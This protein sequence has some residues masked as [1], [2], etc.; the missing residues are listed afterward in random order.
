MVAL[1]PFGA[2]IIADSEHP[3]EAEM[4]MRSEQSLNLLVVA[5][6]ATGDVHPLLAFARALK[7]RGHSVQTVVSSNGAEVAHQLGLN[8][9]V[10]PDSINVPGILPPRM[11]GFVSNSWVFQGFYRYA[12]RR[13]RTLRIMR[14]AYMLIAEKQHECSVVISRV[15]DL[16]AR[17]A[18]ERL[19]IPFACVQLQPAAFRSVHEAFGLPLPDGDTAPLRAARAVM[20]F[21]IDWIVDRMLTGE[22]NRFRSELGLAPVSRILKEWIFSPDLNIGLFPSWYGAPQPDWPRHTHLTGFP[23]F[24]AAEA[25]EVPADADDFLQ[26]GAPPVVFTRSLHRERSEDYFD[27]AIEVCRQ[28][29]LRG[30]FVGR[31]PDS[32]VRRLPE[33]VCHFP[34]VPF[35]RLLRRAAALVHHGGMGTTAQAL[36]AGIPQLVVPLM[37]DQWDQ[38]RRVEKLGVGLRL[39]PRRFRGRLAVSKL[40]SLL[41]STQIRQTCHCYADMVAKDDSLNDACHLVEEWVSCTGRSPRSELR[42]T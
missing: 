5:N 2:R 6:G 41:H 8:T 22:V 32:V 13:E 7:N 16:A 10:L 39:H 9:V 1:E 40:A 15:P 3:P 4:L 21:G 33:F 24:D 19:G 34:Y 12:Q 28:L 17:L 29:G 26:Q 31:V 42:R 18:R 27:T 35:S 30:I 20:W 36:A 23:L 25:M 37:D 38:A 14:W 11:P